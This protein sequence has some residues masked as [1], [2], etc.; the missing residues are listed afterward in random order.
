[1]DLVM[2]EPSTRRP[3]YN[4]GRHWVWERCLGNT[5]HQK[6]EKVA[7]SGRF[8]A[9]HDTSVCALGWWAF[10]TTGRD[11]LFVPCIPKIQVCGRH[12]TER[13]PGMLPALFSC[14]YSFS[15]ECRGDGDGAKDRQTI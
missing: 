12:S 4:L 1:M 6:H 14:L 3:R 8:V 10:V 5:A 2:T 11:G 15:S 9:T 13:T 7:A